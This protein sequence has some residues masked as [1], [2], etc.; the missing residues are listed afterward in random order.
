MKRKKEIAVSPYKYHKFKKNFLF[1]LFWPFVTA[2]NER[3]TLRSQ[4]FASIRKAFPSV[5]IFKHS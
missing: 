3:R 1:I 2:Q 4:A 5:R